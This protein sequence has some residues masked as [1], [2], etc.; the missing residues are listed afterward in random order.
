MQLQSSFFLCVLDPFVFTMNPSHTLNG[1]KIC[2][3]CCQC[4]TSVITS[5]LL[6]VIQTFLIQGFCLENEHFPSGLC[7]TCRITITE[8]I[9]KYFRSAIGRKAVE[10]YAK[11]HL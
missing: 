5:T 2:L 10:P 9:L 8:G 11:L 1:A 6:A 4:A 7:T 3:V